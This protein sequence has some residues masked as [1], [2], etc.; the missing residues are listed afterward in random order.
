VR[1]VDRKLWAKALTPA[2]F[3]AVLTRLLVAPAIIL[4][5]S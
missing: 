3:V 4:A 2:K 1:G 5:D